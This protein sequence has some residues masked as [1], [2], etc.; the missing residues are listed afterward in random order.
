MNVIK[1]EPDV[2]SGRGSLFLQR[3]NRLTSTQQADIALVEV[4]AP[5][6][7]GIQKTENKLNTVPVSATLS[8]KREGKVRRYN[9]NDFLV[10]LVLLSAE[11]AIVCQFLLDVRLLSL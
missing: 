5:K 6:Q 9:Q 1:L 8:V 11:K 3:D 2:G 7:K 4:I 10:L